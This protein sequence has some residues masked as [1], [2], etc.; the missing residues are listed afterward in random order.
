VI[1][2]T[3]A[4]LAILLEEPEAASFEVA[5]AGAPYP[6]VS[7]ATYLETGIV[8]DA[9][10][11]PLRSRWLDSFLAC[12][13]IAIE[14]VTAEQAVIARQAYQDFG[15]GS[16]HRAQLNVG[17]CFAYALA[18]AMDEDLLFKGHDFS[19]TD[20]RPAKA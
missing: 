20:V 7:A 15:R 9:R 11:D 10:Q 1:V 2:D 17:D 8:I 13:E 4:L 6:K 19:H 14:P 12:A 3:S 5:I 16:G 18:C